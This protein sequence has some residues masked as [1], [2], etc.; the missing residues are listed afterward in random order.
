MYIKS[1]KMQ[2]FKSFAD[3]TELDFDKNICAIVGPNGSGKSNV[4]DA[5]L[6]VLGEQSV[7]TLR[8]DDKMSDIIF[9]GS[10]SREGLTKASVSILFDNEDHTLPSEFGEVEIKRTI[11]KT[12]ENE[13]FIN[14]SR[15]RLKDITDLILDVSSK[16]NIITQGNI[17]ALVDN[18]S[19]ERRVLFENAAGVLKYKKRKE[20]TLK[21]L[22]NTK[23][24]ITRLNLIIKEV[25]SSLKP[26]EKQKKEAEKYIKIKDNLENIEVSLIASDITNIKERYE[27]IK[28]ENNKLK[29]EQEVNVFLHP[30]ELEKLKLILLQMDEEITKSNEQ[31]IQ[32]NDD[33][34]RLQSQKQIN[35]ERV[36]LS[37]NESAINENLLRLKEE[38]L[39]IE[40]NIAVLDS[41]IKSLKDEYNT[42]IKEYNDKNNTQLKE[43]I[44]I[45]TLKSDYNVKSKELFDLENRVNIAKSNIENNSFLPKSIAAV[46]NSKALSGICDRIENLIEVNDAHKLAISS[47]LGAAKNFIVT[48]DF[49]SAKRAI[50]YLKN[51]GLGRCTFFPLDTIKSR[52]IDNAALTSI[53]NLP[54]FIGIASDLVSYDKK[55]KNIIENQLGNVIIVDSLD[56]AN[57]IGKKID[58]KYKIVSLE[59]DILYSGGAVSG[60]TINTNNDDKLNLLHMQNEYNDKKGLLQS[61]SV[62]LDNANDKYEELEKE[63]S[64]INYKLTEKRVLIENKEK[65]L[66]ETKDKLTYTESNIDGFKNLNNNTLNDKIEEILY[67]LNSKSKEK[68]ILENNLISLKSRKFDLNNKIE[69]LERKINEVNSK[70]NKNE[71]LIKNNE[72]EIGKLEVKMDSLLDNL[73][74]EYNMTYENA[75]KSYELTMDPEEAREIVVKYKN[76][77]KG[78]S[79]INI[80]SI[81]EYDRLSKRYDFLAGQKDD[82]ESSSKELYNIID[83]MDDIMKKRFKETFD[84]ISTEYSIVFRKMFKGGNGVLK[85]IDENDLL[86]TGIS[87]LAVPPGKK[88][89]STSMLSGGEKALTAIC[90][91]FAILNVKPAPFIVLDEVEAPLDEENVSM[92]GDYLKSMQN[93]SQFI[94]ITHK[95]KM[96]EY[97]SN[98]YG[99]TMQESGV[100]KLVSVKLENNIE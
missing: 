67:T 12:G 34:S 99:V 21:K 82:L 4:V 38:K 48:T 33:I 22:D 23:E 5:L 47:S 26:L 64:E 24:N 35:L 81:S 71:S 73:Q 79:N 17:N 14:N 70:Y 85:L 28:L 6:W 19:S 49:D 30:E 92:F 96:M 42:L 91:I 60:G 44:K 58:Y 20:E 40:K 29:K 36:K 27:N 55:Y 32:I 53:K 57:K 41:E 77:L 13:Y 74:N 52:Y 10:K 39:S 66:S 78:L 83:E 100:S 37:V 15:V 25:M 65:V 54:G 45:T 95:K 89:N 87:I 61:I 7:K 80:G 56:D 98:L 76:D 75:L 69:D 8:G 97:A 11:Y 31:I 72:I 90:L 88:L 43:K 50:K 51:F 86:N 16:F 68:E 63:I 1:I 93:I 62:T 46:L 94:L 59:G 2:G 3:K 9:S 84:K 18:K